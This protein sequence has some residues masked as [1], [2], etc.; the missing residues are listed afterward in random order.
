VVGLFG[1]NFDWMVDHVDSLWAFLIFGVGA[2][3]VVLLALV[4]YFRRRG[5]L[6]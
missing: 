6:S 3:I 4:V 2:Q 5:W 1:Q